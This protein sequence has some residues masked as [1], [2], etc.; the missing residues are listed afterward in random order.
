MSVVY[1]FFYIHIYLIMR[2]AYIRSVQMVLAL[3]HSRWCAILNLLWL[4]FSEMWMKTKWKKKNF[5]TTLISLQIKKN[6]N[7]LT[8]QKHILFLNFNIIWFQLHKHTPT[9]YTYIQKDK[10]NLNVEKL[11]LQTRC[12]LQSHVEFNK[13]IVFPL[14]YFITGCPIIII[15]F[16]EYVHRKK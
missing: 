15:T 3:S 13:M 5:N 16:A 2:G 6:R 10:S 4:I 8:L 7:F 9:L 12:W 1:S 14:F 11:H